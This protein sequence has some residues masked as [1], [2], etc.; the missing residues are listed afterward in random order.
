MNKSSFTHVEFV[1]VNWAFDDAQPEFAEGKFHDAVG[2]NAF[3]SVFRYTRGD[4]LEVAHPKEVAGRTF[5]NVAVL[6]EEDGFVESR[7]TCIVVGQSA[8]HIGASDFGAPGIVLFS[9]RR[10]ELTP[11]CM[12][13]SLCK[14]SP[15]G[16]ATS[17]NQ[18]DRNRAEFSHACRNL[19]AQD[20]AV[21]LPPLIVL[22]RTQ[23]EH[24]IFGRDPVGA[25]AFEDP[26]P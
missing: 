16:N 24:L 4:E 20:A 23:N 11:A 17:P 26:V 9:I 12:P 7:L 2:G 25:D 15:K 22:T 8:V 1:A 5:G 19:D 21:L 13:L 3:E 10:Q 14:Y 18:F 6:V